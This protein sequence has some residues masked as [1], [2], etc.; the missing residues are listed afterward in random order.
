[1]SETSD[2]GR[3]SNQECNTFFK[4]NTGLN[5]VPDQ[6]A[7]EVEIWKAGLLNKA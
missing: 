1:M 2:F 3:I 5:Q 4:N 6:Q 7:K